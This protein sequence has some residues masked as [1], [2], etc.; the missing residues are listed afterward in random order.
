[1]YST[2]LLINDVAIEKVIIKTDIPGLD[3]VPARLDLAGADI[4]SCR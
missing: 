2:M 4:E 1:M 3:L